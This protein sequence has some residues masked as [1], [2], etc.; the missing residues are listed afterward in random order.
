MDAKYKVG[1]LV[2]INRDNEMIDAEVFGIMKSISG[3]KPSY[4]LRVGS[5]FYFLDEDRIIGKTYE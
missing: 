5:N 3:E 4:S 1:E 2:I